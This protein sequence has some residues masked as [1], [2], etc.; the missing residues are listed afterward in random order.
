M[1]LTKTIQ[2]EDIIFQDNNR[3]AKAHVCF[4]DGELWVSVTA[5]EEQYDFGLDPLTLKM[6]AYGYKL[7]CEECR[8]ENNN[9]D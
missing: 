3:T 6:L 7:H 4:C 1:S 9:G 2:T 8:K 5:G